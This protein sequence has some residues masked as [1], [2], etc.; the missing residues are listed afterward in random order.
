M[1]REEIGGVSPGMHWCDRPQLWAGYAPTVSCE[2][3][4]TFRCSLA[5][6]L[7]SCREAFWGEQF[8]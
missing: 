6:A 7:K 1:G 8:A 4:S 3:Q 5:T 2:S